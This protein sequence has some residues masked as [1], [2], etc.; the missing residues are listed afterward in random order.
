[1]ATRLS[2][3]DRPPL[4]RSRRRPLPPRPKRSASDRRACRAPACGHL[5]TARAAAR[6]RRRTGWNGG[7]PSCAHWLHWRTGIDL[8]AA[9]EKVR[10]AH[11]LATLPRSA[12]RCARGDLLRQGAGAHP[13][14]DAR[15]R[16]RAARRRPGRNRR[17]RRTVRPRLASR[18]SGGGS[19]S[20]RVA[21]SASAAVDLGRRR[22]DGRD[23]RTPDAEV[24]A[25][26]QSAL[27]AASRPAVPRGRGGAEGRS[28]GE[29]VS[30]AQRR[31]DALA[32]SPRRLGATWTAAQLATATRWSCTWTPADCG[33]RE[34]SG[35]AAA[36]GRPGRS[37]WTTARWTFPRKRRTRVLR[38]L[39]GADGH[40]TDGAGLDVGRKTRRCRLIRRALWRAIA[41][42]VPRLHRPPLRRHHVDTGRRRRRPVSTTWSCCAGVITAPYTRAD[43][44]CRCVL[45]GRRSSCGRAERH[46]RRPR[47]YLRPSPPLEGSSRAPSTRSRSGRARRSTSPTRSMCSTA[48]RSRR[49]RTA[50][51]RQR[52]TR[53]GPVIFQPPDAAFVVAENVEEHLA[54]L[55]PGPVRLRRTAGPS[56]RPRP[57]SSP[58]SD[59]SGT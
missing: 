28:P 53:A 47:R 5:R 49:S 9:R 18:R 38:G 55:E 41:L 4:G 16:G 57:R 11:A 3:F 43:S 39:G 7:F 31:A 20:G 26:V 51:K 10:V 59:R 54:V 42:S 46:W 15:E 29:E 1:M 22:R 34:R 25:V 37:R 14:G 32:C 6:V 17:P 56:A 19:G 44:N 58:P 12:P 35:V 45:T 27:E 40:G 8:G 2:R 52:V 30:P 50:A 33:S 21:A 23:P 13:G 24:G 48:R 36:E